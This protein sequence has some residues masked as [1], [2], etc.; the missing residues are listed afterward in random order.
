MANVR[1]ALRVRPLSKREIAEGTRIILNVDDKIARIRNIKLDYRADGCGDPRERFMEFGFDYCYCSV[2]PDD[3]KY[4]SQEVVFQDLGTTVL[5]EAI[6]GYNVCLFAYGQTGSGKT[7][8]M[9]GT[10]TS[11]GLT[12]RICEGLFCYN[13][14]PLGAAS[15]CRIEVSFLEIYNERVR[16]LLHQGDQKKPYT[17]RV[18]EHPEKGPYVQ[19]LSQHVVTSYEQVV[20][21]LEEGMENRI[22]AATHI[23]DASSRSHAIFTI[24]YTQAILEDNLPSEITSKVNL[25]DLAGSE[26]A[27][28]NYCK[29]R[30]TEGSNINR[31]LVTLGIV[32]SALAHNSQMSSSCQSIN[33]II[34][35]GDSG[36]QGSSPSGSSISGSKRQ[37]FVPYRDSILTWLL[38]DSLGGNSKT[39]M[40]ATVSP[41]SSS[42]NETI[43]TLRYASNA[44]NIINK[45][46]VNEDTNV[47]LIRELREEINRLKAMLRNFELR[48][49]SPAF[50]EER[51]GNL[52]E[53]V[54]QNEL[55]IEQLTKDWTD[56]WTDKAALMEQYNVDIDHGKSRVTIDSGLPHLIAMDDDILST[57]VVIY[58]LKE[59]TTNIG[60]GDHDIVLQGE[61]IEQDHCIIENNFGVVELR[62]ISGALCTVNGQEVTDVCRLCQGAVIVLG[63]SHKFRFNHPA[64]A[65]VLRQ[66]RSER[67]PSFVSDCSLDWLDLSGDYSS[68]KENSF[69]LNTRNSTETVSEEY[70]QWKTDVESSYQQVEEQQRYVE[71]L[72]RQIQVAQVKGEKELEQE[73]TLLNQQILENQQWL[74]KEKQ[75]LTAACQQRKESASQTETKTYAEV[76][77]QNCVQTEVHPSPEEVH[78]KQLLQLE[79]LRKCS[80][81]RAERNIR[82]KRV[83]FQLE[84]IVKKQKLLEAKTT[85]QQLEATCWINDDVL[86]P[87]YLQA[88]KLQDH[89]VLSSSLERTRSS[90]SSILSYYKRRSLP[91]TLQTLPTYSALI[92]RKCKSELVQNSKTRENKKPLRA[93]SI[94]CLVKTSPTGGSCDEVDSEPSIV[95]S[96][97]PQAEKRTIN[98]LINYSN[99]GAT[100]FPSDAQMSKKRQKMDKAGGRSKGLS[101]C[102]TEPPKKKNIRAPVNTGTKDTKLKATKSQSQPTV[103]IPRKNTVLEKNKITAKCE[104]IKPPPEKYAKNIQSSSGPGKIPP[105]EPFSAKTIKRNMTPSTKT[106]PINGANKIS[107]SVDNISKVNH[108]H[109]DPHETGRKWM[110]TERLNRGCLRSNIQGLEHWKEDENSDS[111]ESESYY[112]VDSLSSAYTSAL[113]EQLK[114]EDKERQKYSRRDSDSEDSQM[115]HDSLVERENKKDRHIKRRYNRYKTIGT[116]SGSSKSLT[117]D[118]NSFPLVTTGS[119]TT[120]FSKSFSLDS[121]ADSD[122]VPD[123]DS[124][125]ELPA[126]I[127]WKLQSPRSL[128][129][130]DDYQ[131]N[132]DITTPGE[133]T[134]LE[135]SASFYLKINNDATMAYRDT[136]TT[137][138]NVPDV[139]SHQ[140]HLSLPVFNSEHSLHGLL[141][142]DSSCLDNKAAKT[143]SDLKHDEELEVSTKNIVIKSKSG[144]SPD[145]REELNV[146]HCQD[147]EPLYKNLNISNVEGDQPSTSHIKDIKVKCFENQKPIHE[148]INNDN[149]CSIRPL[150]DFN[151]S[152]H[153]SDF[154][155]LSNNFMESEKNTQK[156]SLD[157]KNVALE[158]I[159]FA[160]TKVNKIPQ[161]LL[162]PTTDEVSTKEV[163]VS[164]RTDVNGDLG[165][166]VETCSQD[167]KDNHK[168]SVELNEVNNKASI[169]QGNNAEKELTECNKNLSITRN[170]VNLNTAVSTVVLK[171][172]NQDTKQN[173]HSKQ[174][175]NVMPSEISDEE[176]KPREMFVL[177]LT[178]E[179]G[180]VHD[181]T[182]ASMKNLDRNVTQV[183]STYVHLNNQTTVLCDTCS[184]FNRSGILHYNNLESEKVQKK[185][186]GIRNLLQAEHI[187]IQS[188]L[189]TTNLVSEVTVY[190]AAPDLNK[191]T[192]CKLQ[193]QHN[194]SDKYNIQK[195]KVADPLQ[196]LIIDEHY[197]T[198]AVEIADMSTSSLMANQPLSV[199]KNKNHTMFVDQSESTN[200]TPLIYNNLVQHIENLGN[201][202]SP[203]SRTEDGS[204][205]SHKDTKSTSFFS[206]SPCLL[207]CTSSEADKEVTSSLPVINLN[208]LPSTEHLLPRSSTLPSGNMSEYNSP[209]HKESRVNGCFS[210]HPGNILSNHSET[211]L[212]DKIC[213]FQHHPLDINS[214]EQSASWSSCENNTGRVPSLNNTQYVLTCNSSGEALIQTQSW[215]EKGIL[216]EEGMQNLQSLCEDTQQVHAL[217]TEPLKPH[218]AG[219]CLN[220]KNDIHYCKPNS[221]LQKSICPPEQAIPT[222]MKSSKLFNSTKNEKQSISSGIIS[223]PTD[224]LLC[225]K[226]DDEDAENSWNEIADQTLKELRMETMSSET[227]CSLQ[228][229]KQVKKNHGNSEKT[230]DDKDDGKYGSSMRKPKD[231][232]LINK[233]A[234]IKHDIEENDNKDYEPDNHVTT[235]QGSTTSDRCLQ[236]HIRDT[237]TENNEQS[238][239]TGFFCDVINNMQENHYCV[240]QPLTQDIGSTRPILP[241]YEAIM[242]NEHVFESQCSRAKAASTRY[243]NTESLPNTSEPE[244]SH[245]GSQCSPGLEKMVEDVKGE[246]HELKSFRILKCKEGNIFFKPKNEESDLG[247]PHETG[248]CVTKNESIQEGSTIS[249]PI[250]LHGICSDVHSLAEMNGGIS[251]SRASGRQG[252]LQEEKSEQIQRYVG[253][254][255]CQ[256]IE[257][258]FRV[259]VQEETLL[260]QQT[261]KKLPSKNTIMQNEESPLAKEELEDKTN[262]IPSQNPE[263]ATCKSESAYP[264]LT[265]STDACTFPAATSSVKFSKCIGESNEVL[266]DIHNDSNKCQYQFPQSQ[267]ANHQTEI[268]PSCQPST[269]RPRQETEPMEKGNVDHGLDHTREVSISITKKWQHNPKS[270][271]NLVMDKITHQSTDVLD[272]CGVNVISGHALELTD[273]ALQMKYRSRNNEGF[274]NHIC[275]T[276]EDSGE[277]PSELN[278]S[279]EISSGEDDTKTFSSLAS[280]G[281]TSLGLKIG[282]LESLS[283]LNEG[284]SEMYGAIHTGDPSDF[285]HPGFS[286][287]DMS[288]CTMSNKTNCS[289]HTFCEC[290]SPTMALAKL[291]LAESSKFPSDGSASSPRSESSPQRLGSGAKTMYN[292]KDHSN[293]ESK[294]C[295]THSVTHCKINCCLIDHYQP[296]NCF[297]NAQESIAGHTH[298]KAEGT[299]KDCIPIKVPSKLH[300]SLYHDPSQQTQTSIEE[301]SEN[302]ESLHFTSSDINPFVHSWQQEVSPRAGWRN[303]S[304]NSAS[305]VSCSKLQA[306]AD[307]LMRCSSVDEG[308]NSHSSPFNS[309]LSSYAKP[310]SSTI[311]SFEGND[312]RPDLNS[313]D[314]FQE[315]LLDETVALHT[316]NDMEFV[317]TSGSQVSFEDCSQLDEI[318]ILY[319]SESETC[320]END[321]KISY[322]H[323]THTK[324][325]YRRATKHQRS[326]TDVFSSRK[327]RHQKPVSWSNMQSMSIHLSQLL[328][329]T[330][331]LL[332]N[333]SQQHSENVT[334]DITESLVKK[335]VKDSFTQT[336]E[337]K[338]IQTDKPKINSTH[339]CSTESNRF[340]SPSEINVIVKVV[341]ADSSTYIPGNTHITGAKSSGKKT[342]VRTQSLPN[343]HGYVPA[344]QADNGMSKSPHIRASVPFLSASTLPLS[345]PTSS[346]VLNKD[347]EDI[348]L[349]VA[350][351][352][353][354]GVQTLRFHTACQGNTMMVDRAS[355]PI[356]TLKA[357]KK[358]FNKFELENNSSEQSL[359]KVPQH[360]KKSEQ[361][362]CKLQVTSS[363]T[364]NENIFSFGQGNKENT[365]EVVHCSSLRESPKRRIATHKFQRY[366]SENCILQNKLSAITN[367]FRS[368]SEISGYGDREDR[369]DNLISTQS[370]KVPATTFTGLPPWERPQSLETLYQMAHPVLDRHRQSLTRT[371]KTEYGADENDL[372]SSTITSSNSYVKNEIHQYSPSQVSGF[373]LQ[374][375][376]DGLSVVESECNTDI[377]LGQEPTLASSHK[378]HNYSLQDLP[379][380]N[381]FSNWSGFQGSLQ[382]NEQLLMSYP[383]LSMK[384]S[385]TCTSQEEVESRSR[386]IERLQ[387]ERA[388]VMS[389]VHLEINPQ[390]LTVQL[391]EAKLSYGIGETDALLRVIQTGKMDS[392][393]QVSVKKQ[394]YARHMKV[395]ENLRKER[396]ERLQSF[397]RSRSLSPQKQ[398]SASQTSLSSLRDSDLPSRRREY[399]RQLR[400]DVVD[401]TRIQE[402]KRRPSQCPSE[403]EAMLKDYQKAREE[404]RT[405]IARARDKLRER[406]ELEK[407][408]LLQSTLQKE[409]T[410]MK[411]LVSTS[412]LFTSSSLSLSSGPTSG[413]NSGMTVTPAKGNKNTFREAKTSPV[414]LDLEMGSGRGRSAVRNC[415]LLAPTQNASVPDPN[416]TQ[417]PSDKSSSAEA[418]PTHRARPHTPLLRTPVLYQDLATQVQAS[419]MA[420]V[421]AACSYDIKN[422]FN[423]QAAA[424]WIYQVTEKNVL[425]YY[426][427]FSSPTKHGFIGAGVIKRPLYNVWDMVKDVHARRLYDKSILSSCVHQRVSSTV[428]LVH[429]VMDMSLC[430]L[431]QPR[432]FCCITVES[433]EEKCY[434]LCFQSVHNESMPRPTKDVVRGE[435]LPSA[436]ILQPDNSNG[437]TVTRVIYMV[438]ADFGAPAIPSRL[439]GVVSKRQALVL[440]SLANFFSR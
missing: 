244:Q 394:L 200:I 407:R 365:F 401:S 7:Y 362:N 102:S 116:C 139:K 88:P 258:N 136:S 122:E 198:A 290:L 187:Q 397:R 110:S 113:N 128:N 61:R 121:L 209:K 273:P 277:C 142:Q 374:L 360:R 375:Q 288:T 405:E 15:S 6:K 152:K 172:S 303:C 260:V 366:K 177:H 165:I 194:L 26:R 367:Q 296:P 94:D 62:P 32:I 75:R 275:G 382:R 351:S 150:D 257:Q 74:V 79:L 353:L 188:G 206:V 222:D 428:Q 437:E 46:R 100:I 246:N 302:T 369:K 269:F 161:S 126:E 408:R 140:I 208:D 45:P 259:K 283:V 213:D 238:N 155:D 82:R 211:A 197:K 339:N 368:N 413:Y 239:S 404:A 402:P 87:V 201:G 294:D 202:D 384:Q 212:S 331:E 299:D 192:E 272:T 72:K 218:Y 141:L 376:D 327:M 225:N 215:K 309:H 345:S 381:K 185:L 103:G 146:Q 242:Q 31:S 57:G 151:T 205:D 287:I 415:F 425:V 254:E 147:S 191:N 344:K 138:L 95:E 112:S 69:I 97:S 47:K 243:R 433:K 370:K 253:R 145:L 409:D 78:R 361:E 295:S 33:S 89:V 11:I 235:T 10:P 383:N 42:Y 350:N 27:S 264:G 265:N 196:R 193:K 52:T 77:I 214:N 314:G 255:S 373:D 98:L 230:N 393:D 154:P 231:S 159:G 30:L 91:W 313:F 184:E 12:P 323:R 99:S 357:S 312:S 289:T 18:R 418:S 318:M 280:S 182:D 105:R 37:P 29:D 434:S 19:G 379:L 107:S 5:S 399:L 86:K 129:M 267:E 39:I 108:R 310:V 276:E 274:K 247:I 420:E 334:L 221:E 320:N 120:G 352:P 431:K 127:F 20:A 55:K 143:D 392:Q 262:I 341:G 227:E 195:N 119:V 300:S 241:Y 68:S 395:I 343:L 183:G 179:N 389:A 266:K 385:P 84:R 430:Y 356:L 60:K 400:R 8:T 233:Q 319:T 148:C 358:P 432:D 388:E 391:A 96:A 306:T 372:A 156:S 176:C 56:K 403:I 337:D 317:G 130:T 417:P 17:L 325:R 251:F 133:N 144:A 59:G 410:K 438:Q 422:L 363:Q 232:N 160:K 111:S 48:A 189:A 115:S 38:K 168:E 406:A 106:K 346:P 322:E 237:V 93:V 174:S 109:E 308:L 90:S 340:L 301:M 223:T 207:S 304:F 307:K 377:L 35:D 3:P 203:V 175:S 169:E 13:A 263:N 70:E 117:E 63:K 348:S 336:Y 41:A 354:S 380:H 427:A 157:K 124:S 364:D 439:L 347:S 204:G 21:L 199:V 80:L 135:R 249:V 167:I 125:E 329:E 53:M 355:S 426:K 293:K 67:Q 421:M 271:L 216:P 137:P 173:F 378:S 316:R 92:K 104:G 419:A 118:H 285:S 236:K 332:G 14:D 178:Q 170:S 190:S 390:P 250:L 305:D 25:V 284:K 224:P 330:S 83:K 210:K 311:S 268:S 279:L 36:I 371:T 387:R 245:F 64:E 132:V 181:H 335:S 9:M 1:V 44:K 315:H 158:P 342:N 386:E 359:E 164:V 43:S 114:Q 278:E 234:N 328:Q 123:V 435:I 16:D 396:E 248:T 66:R 149:D 423:G 24:Q 256:T 412:T 217:N 270:E 131:K 101:S 134:A 85:L 226:S 326:S 286:K 186:T 298:F 81:R 163:T 58:Q 297:V 229:D 292:G 153:H 76:E 338:G 333:F 398:L 180:E 23:H 49:I 50:S 291:Q 28:P 321:Q 414:G 252:N 65:A 220:F 22:T 281:L 166:S 440:S 282:S 411:T 349:A 54:R 34:S 261:L 4:A 51:D 228:L 324:P 71:D 40:I 416:I 240:V 429:V 424:G 162:D 73:Q 171:S 2:D 219:D 436:W